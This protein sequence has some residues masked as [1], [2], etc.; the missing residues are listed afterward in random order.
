MKHVTLT[1]VFFGALIGLWA[2]AAVSGRAEAELEATASAS[3]TSTSE[4]SMDIVR[5]FASSTQT[6]HRQ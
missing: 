5:H 1:I 2:L 3:L 4:L 6:V